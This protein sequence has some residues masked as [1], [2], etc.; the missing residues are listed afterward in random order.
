MTRDTSKSGTVTETLIETFFDIDSRIS[1]L[2]TH[3]SDTF[4]QLNSY[5]KPK[6][7]TKY[8]I[9][10][11]SSIFEISL[12]SQDSNPKAYPSK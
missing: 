2:H 7:G 10:S 12:N 4:L 1:N 8:V 5:L 3:S 6:H 9:F 11:N